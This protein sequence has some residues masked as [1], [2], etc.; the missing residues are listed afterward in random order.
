MVAAPGRVHTA[1]ERSGP[2]V[3]WPLLV[4][5]LGFPLHWLLGLSALIWIVLCPPMLLYLWGRERVLIPTGGGVWALFLG[6]VLLSVVSI[7]GFTTLLTFGYRFGLYTSV[8]VLLLFTY[9]LPPRVD[10]ARIVAALAALWAFVI[11]AGVA[12]F[13]LPPLNFRSVLEAVLPGSVTSI[14]FVRQLVHPNIAQVH[15]F[16]GYTVAR[17]AAPFTYT[18]EWG[19]AVALLTPMYVCWWLRQGTRR[20]RVM[21]AALLAVACVPVIASLNRGAWLCLSAAAAYLAVRLALRG[22]ARPLAVLGI[23]VFLVGGLLA[24]TPL[25]GLVSDRTGTGHSDHARLILYEGTVDRVGDSPLIGHGAPQRDPERAS[26]APVGTHGQVWLVAVSHGLPAAALFV[27]FLVVLLV[28]LGRGGDV[29][30]VRLW[31]SATVVCAVIQLPLY[32]L[33]P[34]GMPLVAIIAG[35]GLRESALAARPRTAMVL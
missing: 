27:A 2:R 19:G 20:V 31:G 3:D 15:D 34:A 13:V 11:L 22:Q 12:A 10:D 18:N 4:L 23:A 8:G 5:L 9:N 7:E 35:L 24:V 21:G 29:R 17:P 14:P 28:R 25:G 26:R 1:A 33:L 32:S 30:S 16:L 6:W